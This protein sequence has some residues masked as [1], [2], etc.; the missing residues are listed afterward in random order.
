[1]RNSIHAI[2]LTMVIL[3]HIRDSLTTSCPNARD[4][5]HQC[6]EA[7]PH[8]FP[9]HHPL[10]VPGEIKSQELISMWTSLMTINEPT[11]FIDNTAFIPTGT[12]TPVLMHLALAVSN[13]S[14]NGYELAVLNNIPPC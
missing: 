12:A 14:K 7:E 13:K 9:A 1:M 3:S 5:A 8:S 11:E 6:I 4:L 10:N 2:T